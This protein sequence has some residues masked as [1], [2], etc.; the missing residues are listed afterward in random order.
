VNAKLSILS[1]R[2][3]FIYIYI[4][5]YIHFSKEERREIERRVRLPLE[6]A[7]PLSSYHRTL[8][9][10]G[11]LSSSLPVVV[12]VVVVLLL[13]LLLCVYVRS[14]DLLSHRC[15]S[16]FSSYIWHFY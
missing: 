15:S 5:I 16:S 2:H 11:V 9:T 10:T 3:I 7:L 6:N 4:Y 1:S 12:I 8:S 13:P 14:R